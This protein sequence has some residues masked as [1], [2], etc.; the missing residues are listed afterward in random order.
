MK[1][2][3]I[4][5]VI[6]VSL[7][8]TGFVAFSAYQGAHRVFDSD[9]WKH[10]VSSRSGMGCPV[11]EGMSRDRVLELLG[12]PDYPEKLSNDDYTF[13]YRIPSGWNGEVKGILY[14]DFD[15]SNKVS[16][17]GYDDSGEELYPGT[18]QYEHAQESIREGIGKQQK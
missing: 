16:K 9:K 18:E 1:K 15:Q 14:F 13:V 8:L 3:L 11:V 7:A 2:K 10:D 17:I 5:L 6:L 4:W 12:P